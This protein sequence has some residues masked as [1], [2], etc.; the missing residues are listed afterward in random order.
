VP[1]GD[2]DRP[3]EFSVTTDLDL[4]TATVHC[5]GFTA[6]I[7]GPSCDADGILYAVNFGEEGTIGRVTADGEASVWATLPAGSVG[8]GI[9]ISPDGAMYV[10]DYTGH[11]VLRID[12]ES[13]AITVHAHQ[14]LMNQPNDLAI[15]PD[16]LIF[17]SDPNWSNGTG[18]LWRVDRDGSTTLLEGGMGTTNGIEVSPDAGT[19]YVNETVQ[20]TV[21]AYDLAAEGTIDNKRLI[22]HFADHGLDG[23]RCDAEGT[24]W[25][26]RHGKGTVVAL[27]SDGEVIREIDLVSGRLCTN[28]AFGGVDG[29]TVHVTVAD[30]G[31]VERF[32]TAVP[33]RAPFPRP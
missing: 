9:V 17:A 8:N 10:A 27:S 5:D 2:D 3:K 11:N 4:F 25:V 13:R 14:P 31:T 30:K 18:Q 6:G 28:V 22:H 12:P 29:R 1:A 32:R 16:G 19:L 24:L 21:W 23:M 15:R 7:E 20:R 26:A 33:G